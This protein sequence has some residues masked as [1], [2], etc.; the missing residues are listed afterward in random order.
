MTFSKAVSAAALAFCATGLAAQP[1]QAALAQPAPARA[2]QLSGPER[3]ALS[4]LQ[5]TMNS[6]DRAAQDAALARARTAAQSP[7]ARYAVAYLQ[8]QIASARGDQALRGQAIDAMVDS[9]QATPDEMAALLAAQASRTLAARD[10][11]ATDR[12]L[13]RIIELQPNNPAALADH[14]ELKAQMG[15]PGNGAI[16]LARAVALAQ[17]QGRP[18]PESWYQRGLALAFDARMAPAGIAIGRGLVAAYPT[19]ANWRDALLAYR[20]LSPADPALDIDVRRLLR[21]SQGLSGERDYMEYAELAVA[22]GLI[23]EAKT[24][25]DDGVARGMVE[26]NRVPPP[27]AAAI[28]ARG[29]LAGLRTGAMAATGTGS[30]ARTAADLHFGHGQYAEAAELYRAALQKG[31]EDPNLVNS[32]LGAALALAGRRPEAEVALRAVTG[33][34]ADLAGFWLAWLAR[35]PV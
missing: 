10:L 4:A 26:M 32:R 17:A 31:G 7:Q 21:A 9:G 16:L 34:R 8:F 30:Q 28:A 18:A 33:P 20:D 2:L 23:G 5:G 35:R 12:L 14:G 27:V 24:T 29:R 6:P 13:T 1:P 19:P 11:R 15:E 22:A 25:L 3:S